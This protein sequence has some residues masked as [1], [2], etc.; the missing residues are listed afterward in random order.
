VDD[1]SLC[2]VYDAIDILQEKWTLHIVRA[3]LQGPHGFNELA[4]AVGGANATT[5]ATRL[6]HLERS[7]IVHKTTLSLMP[8]RSRYELT[9]AGIALQRVIEAIDGW[10]RSHLTRCRAAG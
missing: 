5:L 7:G 9:D 8:P 10:A 2:P 6:E 3:L 4:R 1:G